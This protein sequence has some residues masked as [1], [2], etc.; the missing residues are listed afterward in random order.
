[1]KR[2]LFLVPIIFSLCLLQAKGQ[3]LIIITNPNPDYVML[4]PI[5]ISPNGRYIIGNWMQTNAWTYNYQSR[6]FIVNLQTW[7][8]TNAYYKNEYKDGY[9]A[10][11]NNYGNACGSVISS[12]NNVGLGYGTPAIRDG[13]YYAK[14]YIYDT[15]EITA[16]GI[17]DNKTIVGTIWDPKQKPVIWKFAETVISSR[18]PVPTS[19]EENSTDYAI[20][21]LS[22][23]NDEKTIIGF[24]SNGNSIP[25]E[26]TYTNG[27]YECKVLASKYVSLKS[28]LKSAAPY[29][30]FEVKC[31][32]DNHE[33]ISGTLKDQEGIIHVARYSVKNDVLDVLGSE[34]PDINS[35][36]PITD[37]GTMIPAGWENGYNTAF[38][39]SAGS[40][41]IHRI[42]DVFPILS[43]YTSI[44]IKAISS[45]GLTI[46]GNSGSELFVISE[47]NP[48]RINQI[49]AEKGKGDNYYYNL[50]GCKISK[51]TTHGLY[52]HN[53]QK[54]IVR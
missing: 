54:I 2:I 47:A 45:D 51:P 44:S 34:N 1:M 13:N 17:N 14:G 12:D 42:K 20:V 33:W 3:K 19:I 25:L 35:A 46:L 32:S 39:W 38:Y 22:I 4:E 36:G 40:K 26:W 28:D 37:D 15:G 48:T 52:I 10:D 53:G 8:E 5:G 29:V 7:Q 21:P 24:A 50:S 27:S 23:S 31:I 18:L 30:S 6:D 43:D 41:T 49:S 9:F 11:V 16:Y